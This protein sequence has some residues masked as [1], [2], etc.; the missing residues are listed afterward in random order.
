MGGNTNYTILPEA[1]A[2]YTF[3]R[4]I[5]HLED[6]IN[7]NNLFIEDNE[8]DPSYDVIM[9]FR[10]ADIKI[11]STDIT[12]YLNFFTNKIKLTKKVNV[13]FVSERVPKFRFLLSL[14]ERI[15]SIYMM[16]VSSFVK[17]EMAYEQLNFSEKNDFID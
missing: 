15:A 9:D 5:I 8:Y 10:T 17:I 13:I 4:G 1:K 6:I 3:F 16:K 14:Y 12:S 7:L 2:I 11:F